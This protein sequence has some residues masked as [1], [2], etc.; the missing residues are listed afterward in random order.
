MTFKL[1]N[2]ARLLT[3]G[4][5][6]GLAWACTVS[7]KGDFTFQEGAGATAGSSGSG[8]SSG[9][10]GS[11]GKG[12]GGRAGA[13]GSSNLGGESGEA[14]QTGGGQGGEGGEGKGGTGGS[15]CDTG[16]KRCDGVCIDVMA[17]DDNCGDCDNVCGSTRFCVMG[18]CQLDCRSNET[19]CNGVCIDTN[20]DPDHCGNCDTECDATQACNLGTCS[21]DCGNNLTN[22]NGACVNLTD[23]PGYCGAC[24]TACQN[25]TRCVASACDCAG[26]G[27]T[28]PTCADD[29]DECESDPCENGGSC[30]NTAGGYACDCSGT[31]FTGDNCEV[32]VNECDNNPCQNGS[33]CNNTDGGYTCDCSGTGYTGDNCEIDVNECANDPCQN[34]GDCT[35]EPGGYDCDCE[36]TGYTGNNCQTDVNECANNPCLHGGDCTNEA[37]G[38]R[39][40]CDGT[41]YTGNNCQTD[42]N[43][44]SPTNPCQNG[45]T[46]NNTPGSYTCSCP[47]GWN[48][49]NQCR[50][51]GNDTFTSNGCAL[52]TVCGQAVNPVPRFSSGNCSQNTAEFADWWCQLGGYERAR[53][54]TE[55][56]TGALPTLYY[57]GGATEVLNQCSQV[58]PLAGYG[59]Q[60]Y[61]TGTESLICQPRPIANTL[62]SSV[63]LCGTS[64]YSI[65]NFFPA[66]SGLTATTGC[67]PTSSTQA[68]LVTRY[69]TGLVGT[70]LRS[71]LQNGGIILTEYGFSDDVWNL[72][73]PVTTQAALP[74]GPCFDNL[75]Q[76][77]RFN[78]GDTFWQQNTWIS[79]QA[80]SMEIGCGYP[81]QQ[82]PLLVPLAGWDATNVSVG[83][84]NLGMGRFY[85][86]DFDWQDSQA[87]LAYTNTQMGWMITHRR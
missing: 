28:G 85:A 66:G 67:T 4:L 72:I 60:P 5:G 17:D 75:P 10:G 81:V 53:S 62:R 43:E 19:L 38:Y 70:T 34:G 41:G 46:C 54:Y 24:D 51:R 3:M 11:A 30:R 79:N 7:D 15:S 44:C 82:F 16:Q 77:A 83:Y 50:C 64:S 14:G 25:N 49:A 9:K 37:G 33:R 74:T 71:Y 31:G 36:G 87:K 22:C 45:G 58:I 57:N 76:V 8:A 55:I 80:P 32:D 84:R 40:D 56:T 61:C 29:I 69:G 20:V 73:F 1:L 48:P 6:L 21:L 13:A 86:T 2:G 65:A 42:I 12:A 52:Q 47:S 59:H 27:F 35:N 68:L 26:S 78:A 18:V 63:M 23:N 39:C